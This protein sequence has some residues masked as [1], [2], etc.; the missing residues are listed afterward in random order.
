[1]RALIKGIAATLIL[2][3]LISI[4]ADGLAVHVVT[5]D[6]NLPSGTSQIAFETSASPTSLTPV[7]SLSPSFSYPDHSF[8]SWNTSPLGTGTKYLNG[9]TYS[10]SS[11][12]TLYAQWQAPIEV[13]T[14]YENRT[15]SDSTLASETKNSAA[16]LTL[17]SKLNPS[18]SNPGYAFV[19]WNTKANGS[20][21]SYLDGATYSFKANIVLYAQ[22]TKV[23]ATAIPLTLVGVVGRT[24][25]PTTIQ[26][27]A[28]AIS[29]K[30]FHRIE[31]VQVGR[32]KGGLSSV[33]ALASS[34]VKLI[35]QRAGHGVTMVVHQVGKV[36]NLNFA[37][38]FAS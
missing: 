32:A 22:W 33:T 15:T 21:A 35:L 4:P 3:L 13:V 18:F 29:S 20:G 8:Q 6:E 17:F 7:G 9:A 2:S 1:M 23:I 38:V 26:E 36:G 19:S 34:L 12:I 25:S 28:L 30:H 31:V 24:H 27:L 10:F 37:E 5:F 14:F 11:N 16:P